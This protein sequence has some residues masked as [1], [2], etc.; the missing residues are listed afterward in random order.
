MKFETGLAKLRRQ[1]ELASNRTTVDYSEGKDPTVLKFGEPAVEHLE[2]LNLLKNFFEQIKTG[3]LLED[4]AVETLLQLRSEFDKDNDGVLNFLTSSEH[5]EE[6]EVWYEQTEDLLNAFEHALTYWD[7]EEP[8]PDVLDE[9][10]LEISEILKD[11]EPIY[12]LLPR[13]EETPRPRAN[14]QTPP[15]PDA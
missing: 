3:L 14:H 10:W 2:Y 15:V 12:A 4:V 8:D 7:G 1:Q 9:S 11:R 13:D 5:P 6:A